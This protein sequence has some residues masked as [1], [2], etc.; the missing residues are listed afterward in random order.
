MKKIF[1]TFMI[2]ATIAIMLPL[3]AAAQTYTTRRVYRNGRYQTV[4]V[5]TQTTSRRNYGYNN[6][7]RTAR[8]TPQEQR[9]LARERYRYGR[10]QNRV[11]RDGVITNKEARKLNR[12]ADKYGRRVNRARNN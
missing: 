11:V 12:R 7:Y 10:L 9:R 5:Y 2:M 4:R 1:A 3:A 8:I 6:R